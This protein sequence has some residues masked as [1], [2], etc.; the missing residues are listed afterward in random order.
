MKKSIVLLVLILTGISILLAQ[1]GPFV[2]RVYINTRM[3]Q[4]IGLKDAAEGITDVFAYGVEGPQLLGMS[5]KD[6]EKLELYSVPSGSWS[7]NLNNFP[8]KAPYQIEKDGETLFN[9][10]AIREIRFALNFLINRKYIVDEILGGAGFPMYTMAVPGQPGTMKYNRIAEEFEFSAEGNEEAAIDD[11]NRAMEEAA[12]LPENDGRLVKGEKYWEF[13]GEPVEI[14]FVIRV[15]DPAGRL[16]VGNYVTDQLEKAGFMVNK[17][18]WDRSKSINTVYY[19][20]PADYEWNIYTEGWTAGATRRYWEHIVA[21]MYA[22]WYGF[23]P[24]GANPDNWNYKNEALGKY[25]KNAYYGRYTTTDEYWEYALKAQRLG[26]KD[27][28]RLYLCA[29]EQYFAANKKRLEERFAYGLGDGINEW[30]FITAKTDDKELTVTQFSAMGS[31]FMSA[32]NP[33]GND[34]FSDTYSTLI[35]KALIS[36]GSFESPVSGKQTEYMADWENIV[37]KVRKDGKEIVGEVP[38]PADAIKYNPKTEKWEEVGQGV[39]AQSKAT[40]SFHFNNWH[41]GIRMSI[42]D[43]FYNTAF[44]AEW[45]TKDNDDDKQYESAYS[46]KIEGNIDELKGWIVH[47]DGTITAYFDYNFPPSEARVASRGIPDFTASAVNGPVVMQS[48]DI[49]EAIALLVTGGSQSGIQYSISSDSEYEIDVIVP[50]H[51]A[52]IKAKLKEM[53]EEGHVPA[54]LKGRITAEE[55]KKRYKASIDFIEEHGHA[56]IGN[57]PF[58]LNEYDSETNFMELTANRDWPWSAQHW[59]D[60]F[61]V[62]RIVINNISLPT[63]VPAGKDFEIEVDLSKVVY[64]NVTP[65]QADSG[66]VTVYIGELKGIDAQVTDEGSFKIRVPGSKTTELEGTKE[67]IVKAELDGA[68]PVEKAKTVVFW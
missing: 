21:Q 40:Y 37:T 52:D 63:I 11:I 23:M 16:R 61:A 18:L 53:Y 66:V 49:F 27:A 55:A 28:M 26:L 56:Y 48:W 24:G 5:K 17:K 62:P 20:N 64:P 3:K 38:V 9:P 6:R 39:T 1:N 58:V 60:K 36:A 29:Q 33:I 65:K 12:T 10:F 31:L 51:V 59:L 15:D 32:W 8:G 46:A 34:G 2:D 57:G 35:S 45:A 50:D 4:E 47:D 25:T 44:R 41:N 14:T 19:G 22:P 30:M 68:V 42:N 13:D 43:L 67:I 7:L 54:S